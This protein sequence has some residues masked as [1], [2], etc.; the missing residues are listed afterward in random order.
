MECCDSSRQQTDMNSIA[1]VAWHI[2]NLGVELTPA[3]DKN[4][5]IIFHLG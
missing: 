4:I 5:I 1:S 2:A 3:L